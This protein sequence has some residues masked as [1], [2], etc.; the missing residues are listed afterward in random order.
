ML[1]F[2]VGL[3][4]SFVRGAVLG[5]GRLSTNGVVG[6]L[7]GGVKS[8]NT[9][10]ATGAIFSPSV[11]IDG[12]SWKA[13]AFLDVSMVGPK[14]AAAP[15]APAPI[16]SMSLR[17][18][19]EVSLIVFLRFFDIRVLLGCGYDSKL[20]DPQ[21]TAPKSGPKMQTEFHVILFLPQM[22]SHAGGDLSK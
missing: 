7:A 13:L 12:G 8:H 4:F 3:G 1:D 2:L 14:T 10:S 11:V 18:M 9:G 16:L 20:Q 15:A 19:P 6:G 22:H 17:V 21:C 5:I